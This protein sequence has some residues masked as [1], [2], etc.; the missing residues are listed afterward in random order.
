MYP[1]SQDAGGPVEAAGPRETP[2]VINPAIYV[3]GPTCADIYIHPP[4]HVVRHIYLPVGV[5]IV[6][7][8]TSDVPMYVSIYIFPA[9][10]RVG[11][12]YA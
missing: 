10:V 6:V 7:T 5:K 11:P 1:R 12:P 9:T 8:A 4:H 3:S 2:H